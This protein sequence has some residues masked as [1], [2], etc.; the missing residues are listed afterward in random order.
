VTTP[1]TLLCLSYAGGTASAVYR[2]WA[3]WLSPDITVVP[4]DLP[5]CGSRRQH[6]RADSIPELLDTLA[7]DA[8]PHVRGARWG[9]FG[10]SFGALLAYELAR[11][12]TAHDS[13]GNPE[14][15]IVSGRRPPAD[16]PLSPLPAVDD[17]MFFDEVVSWG[18]VPPEFLHR[19]S[20]RPLILAGL[21]HD[22]V[23]GAAYE[24]RNDPLLSCPVRVLAAREDPLVDVDRL[25]QWSSATTGPFSIHLFRGNHFY[26]G[27]GRV[28]APLVRELITTLRGPLEAAPSGLGVSTPRVSGTPCA[29][30]TLTGSRR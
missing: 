26:F 13:V 11:T 5:G 20:L 25:R 24:H 7:R 17:P 22:I 27:D 12:L 30:Q 1:T 28:T 21:R 23:L 19:P 10:H 8:L 6:S 15:V 2:D 14:A 29:A 16:R 9:V 4:L 3:L 18:G